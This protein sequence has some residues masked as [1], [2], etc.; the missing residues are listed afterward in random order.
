MLQNEYLVTLVA[1]I[2][3]DTAENEPIFGWI[4]LVQLSIFNCSIL[5]LHCIQRCQPCGPPKERIE[6]LNI[7]SW[8]NCIQPKIGSFSAV[9]TPIFATKGSFCS[10]FQALHVYPHATPDFCL[11]SLLRT[12]FR[13]KS[14]IF[15]IFREIFSLFAEFEWIFIGISQKCRD[16]EE[17]DTEN[18]VFSKNLRNFGEI[19]PKWFSENWRKVQYSIQ[20]NRSSIVLSSP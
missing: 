10:I 14:R 1:K 2:G 16:L 9:S 12:V 15:S 11:F 5:S 8:T 6:L 3:L 7:E 19:L 4:Q 17:I 13:E 20:F 18:A